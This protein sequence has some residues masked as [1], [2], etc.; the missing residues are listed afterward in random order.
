MPTPLTHKDVHA[1]ATDF[2]PYVIFSALRTALDWHLSDLGWNH[3]DSTGEYVWLS[4]ESAEETSPLESSVS[5][6]SG[7]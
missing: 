3:T 7:P 5:P 6:R 4:G 1:P 2:F